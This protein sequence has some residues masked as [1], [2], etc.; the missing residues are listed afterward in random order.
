ML[1]AFPAGCSRSAPAPCP[2]C[3]SSTSTRATAAAS[4]AADDADRDGRD[5]RGW[6]APV[7]PPPRRP[8]RRELAGCPGVDIKADGGYV[9]APPSIHPGTRRPYRWVRD[10]LDEMPAP[11]RAAITPAPPTSPRRCAA[12]GH[13][14][15]PPRRA[16]HSPDRLL[17]AHLRAVA[18]AAEGTRRTTLYGAAR[19]VARMV[20]AGAITG[21]R[22]GRGADRGRTRAG[23]DAA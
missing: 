19:G 1:E 9:C 23:A 7:L 3:A 12:T 2:G 8:D 18:N 15:A 11:L 4:T 5:R 16:S 22:R 13:H 6:L 14:H 17:T 20:T 10:G 21:H